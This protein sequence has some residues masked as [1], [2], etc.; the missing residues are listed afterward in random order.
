MIPLG[1]SLCAGQRA[2]PF[3]AA[4]A[5]MVLKL[6]GLTLHLQEL[7]LGQLLMPARIQPRGATHFLMAYFSRPLTAG[8]LRCPTPAGRGERAPRVW[9]GQRSSGRGSKGGAGAQWVRG[10]SSTARLHAAAACSWAG[11]SATGAARDTRGTGRRDT[12]PLNS[13]RPGPAG[14]G[15]RGL[16]GRGKR[17]TRVAGDGPT[18]SAAGARKV[19][20]LAPPIEA[21]TADPAGTLTRP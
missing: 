10:R 7:W 19:A 8:P 5:E 6:L 14:A 9:P 20:T 18:G 1:A 2:R 13:D 4:R 11:E 16:A 15:A 12:R 21:A 3:F 17:A